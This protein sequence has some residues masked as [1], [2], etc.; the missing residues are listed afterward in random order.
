M[1]QMMLQGQIQNLPQMQLFNQMMQGKN[2]NQRLETLLNAAKSN[3]FDI[4]KKI[5]S[6]ADLQSLKLH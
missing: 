6:E 3:G 5:F 4:N 2:S 1:M